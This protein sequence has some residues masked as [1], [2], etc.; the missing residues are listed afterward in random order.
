MNLGGEGE[1]LIGCK[2]PEELGWEQP[3][4]VDNTTQQGL[5]FKVPRCPFG[6]GSSREKSHNE[7]AWRLPACFAPPPITGAK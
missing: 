2:P 7:L 3:L 5:A 1:A 4:K 6:V